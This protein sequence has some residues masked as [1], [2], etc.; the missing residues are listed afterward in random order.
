MQAGRL[1]GDPR[2]A[3][4]VRELEV[5][6]DPAVVF[7]VVAEDDLV[8]GMEGVAP[9]AQR[10]IGGPIELFVDAADDIEG[11]F[12]EAEPDVEAVLLD[13]L[14]PGDISPPAGALAAQPP[15]ELVDG[16]VVALAQ[17]WRRGELEGRGQAA[18][19]ATKDCHPPPFAAPHEGR[20]RIGRRR[21]TQLLAAQE[22]NAVARS[23]G[24][25]NA[26]PSR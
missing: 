25:M 20:D 24:P 16:D 2:N 18:C 22:R 23:P 11:V 6:W 10:G 19:S 1:A 7:G 15:A 26:V 8:G 3:V 12:V 13:P 14:C 21:W 4:V 17:L 9:G 5:P